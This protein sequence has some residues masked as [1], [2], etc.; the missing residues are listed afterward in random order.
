MSAL[1]FGN[2]GLVVSAIAAFI[3]TYFAIF[4]GWLAAVQV[5]SISAAVGLVLLLK[6]GPN[7][8][9]YQASARSWTVGTLAIGCTVAVIYYFENKPQ[10]LAPAYVENDLKPIVSAPVIAPVQAAPPLPRRDSDVYRCVD[11]KGRTT[12]INSKD[13]YSGCTIAVFGELLR[14]FRQIRNKRTTTQRT[15]ILTAGILQQGPSFIQ[16]ALP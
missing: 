10:S 11:E 8:K 3:W 12:Y 2:K 14:L 4:T 6:E 13:V 1:L 15:D 9:R 16:H 5:V 7:Y